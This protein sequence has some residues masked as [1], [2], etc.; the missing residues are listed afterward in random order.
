MVKIT[1]E[2]WYW[3]HNVSECY[4]H[5]QLTL[6]YRRSVFQDEI[7]KEMLEIMS[8]FKERY[9]IDIQTVGYDKNHVHILCRFLPKYSGGQ[10]IR[11]LKSITSRLLFK[12]FPDIK[13][14]LWGGEFWS[15][16]YYI[17]TVSGRGDKKVIENYI[18]NQGRENDI[19]Q[20][21][22]FDI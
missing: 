20:L 21:R 6:K 22:L 2:L 17:G 15:D 8:G 9:H 13:K 19:Q 12:K 5:L 7:E 14:Q 16:G 1:K 3:H 18:K 11:L 10:V 4:Y